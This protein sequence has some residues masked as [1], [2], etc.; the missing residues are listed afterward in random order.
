MYIYIVLVCILK[1]FLCIF[2]VCF[3]WLNKKNYKLK[4]LIL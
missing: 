3:F 4:E 2:N 1:K